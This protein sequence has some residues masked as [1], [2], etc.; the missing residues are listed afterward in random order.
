MILR[1]NVIKFICSSKMYLIMIFRDQIIIKDWTNCIILINKRLYIWEI[2][3][4][5]FHPNIK[6]TSWILK[7]EF[8]KDQ[9]RILSLKILKHIKKYSCLEKVGKICLVY[10]YPILLHLLLRWELPFPNLLPKYS[11]I[12]L[13]PSEE[14]ILHFNTIFS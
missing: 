7:G 13:T 11:Q 1:Q 2:R 8:R 3:N 14:M 9:W 5:N 10:I 6:P 12:D 4:Q